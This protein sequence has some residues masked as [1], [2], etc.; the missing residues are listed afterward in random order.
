MAVAIVGVGLLMQAGGNGGS[1]DAPDPTNTPTGPAIILQ[2]AVTPVLEP[3]IADAAS[4]FNTTNPTVSGRA[5]SVRVTR[6]DSVSIWAES[7]G[8]WTTLNHPQV[9]IPEASYAVAF[10][11]EVNLRYST[12]QPSLAQT[13][14]IWGAY[15][16]R[17][18][19]IIDAYN[20]FTTDAVQEAAVEG[21]WENIGGNSRWQFIKI[22]FARPNSNGSGLAALLTLAGEY[23]GEA[24]LTNNL[25]SDAALLDW[26][27]PVINA[28]P[29]FSTLGPDPAL[30]MANRGTSTGEI[31]LLPESQWLAHFEDLN[32]V[33]PIELFY[34]DFYV[35]L[36]FPYTVWDGNETSDDER[37]AAEDFADFLLGPDQQ[38]AA[39][40]MG[41]RP[42][43][44]PDLNQ[45]TPFSAAQ[46]I[47]QEALGGGEVTPADRP[48]MLALLR[49]FEN[50]RTAP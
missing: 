41:F 28:V 12:I 6:Q 7:G 35:L 39:G 3:W 5:V 33:E 48:G 20:A 19:V 42:A 32:G 31:G 16:T 15:Q 11:N 14:I 47:V 1:T 27:E 26:L 36:D 8:A 24:S 49:W 10:A 50:F 29:N 34:P 46:G 38:R 45:L 13:P 2:V 23:A 17:S 37:R 43:N 21:R 22:A 44:G 30:T 18:T 9:W 40:E 4:A 25:M